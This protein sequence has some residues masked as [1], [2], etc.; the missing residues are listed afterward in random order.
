MPQ[1]TRVKRYNPNVK[2]YKFGIISALLI[3]LTIYLLIDIN[4]RPYIKN[5]AETTAENLAIQAI[6][7]AVADVLT[8]EDITYDELSIVETNSSGSITSIKIDT[9]KTNILKSKINTEIQKRISAY[10]KHSVS[11][12]FGSLFGRDYLAGR[13]PYICIELSMSGVANS[14]ISN[15]FESAG[16]NQTLHKIMLDI[17][18][19]IYVV[20]PNNTAYTTV[21]TNVCIAETIIVGAVP[22][23]FVDINPDSID[24]K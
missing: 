12:P 6:N 4:L 13:G 20:L 23:T 15:S 19:K 2:R 11:V 14:K 5:M 9:I 8:K 24:Q 21:T 18:A 22:N 3:A 7:Q 10:D 1:K 17:T 16:I